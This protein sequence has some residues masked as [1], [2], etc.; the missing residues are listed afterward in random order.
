MTFDVMLFRNEL[1]EMAS[2]F[3][4][5]HYFKH[6]VQIILFKKISSSFWYHEP[7]NTDLYEY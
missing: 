2:T 4:E 7:N 3:N 6:L 1:I 5:I